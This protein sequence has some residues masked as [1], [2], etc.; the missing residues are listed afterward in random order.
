MKYSDIRPLIRSGDLLAW[1]TKGVGVWNKLLI[2]LGRLGQ[3]TQWTHVG[4][5]WVVGDR[6]FVLD[7]VAS[8][9][10]DYPLSQTLPVYLISRNTPLTDEQLAFAISKKGQQYSYWECFLAWIKR[11]DKTNKFWQCAEYAS[12]VLGLDCDATPSAVIDYVMQRGG[13]MVFISS[14]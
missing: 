4:V 5:A 3:L 10:R 9:V 14:Q 11:N 7:A 1:D 2:W 8:G 12:A 13:S 6:V